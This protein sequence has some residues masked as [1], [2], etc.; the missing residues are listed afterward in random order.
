MSQ[1]IKRLVKKQKESEYMAKKDIEVLSR[2]KKKEENWQVSKAGVGMLVW[3]AG[4]SLLYRS[5][6][7]HK[8]G[9]DTGDAIEK[10]RSQMRQVA[11]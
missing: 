1:W 4:I 3:E 8:M 5:Y 6:D 9:R 7:N 11:L 2:V 10:V